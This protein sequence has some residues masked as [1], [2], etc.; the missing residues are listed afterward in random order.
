MKQKN[1]YS[2]LYFPIRLTIFYFI[3]LL[4]WRI[5]FIGYNDVPDL[6]LPLVKAISLDISMICGVIIVGTIPWLAYLMIGWGWI[7][8]LNKW[9]H[10]FLW[11]F[12]CVVEFGSTLLFKEWGSTLDARAF[13]YLNHPQEAWASVKDFI[14]FCEAYDETVDV[15]TVDELWNSTYKGIKLSDML[16]SIPE[17]KVDVF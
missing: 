8:Q 10:I 6:I 11:I 16:S 17:D 13:A 3:G 2:S 9:L 5:L 4:L 7:A 12:I 14:S 1:R 15:A